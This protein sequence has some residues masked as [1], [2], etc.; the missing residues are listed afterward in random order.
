MKRLERE[1][2]R[3]ARLE[4]CQRLSALQLGQNTTLSVSAKPFIPLATSSQ[5]RVDENTTN[6]STTN[7]S[8]TGGIIPILPPPPFSTPPHQLSGTGVPRRPPI[9]SSSEDKGTTTDGTTTDSSAV[10]SKKKPHKRGQRG[11]K[12]KKGSRSETGDSGA[13]TSTSSSSKCKSQKKAG[14]MN[15]I[16]IPEFNGTADKKEKVA[17]DFRHWAQALPFTETIMRTSF[18]CLR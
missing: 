11:K 18:S 2:L 13:E 17:E 8:G 1:S 14:V 16:Q 5:V 7:G 10:S 12:G 4:L 6:R 9:D 15:K 3:K